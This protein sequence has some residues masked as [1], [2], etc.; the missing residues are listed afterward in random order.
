MKKFLMPRFKDRM[1]ERSYQYALV[2]H[3]ALYR[4]QGSAGATHR[5]AYSRGYRGDPSH[6]SRNSHGHA[7][8]AAGK[9]N[10]KL[11]VKVDDGKETKTK[12]R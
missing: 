11:G 5:E 2:S 4:K 6:Y 10:A 3:D 8:Y 1:M 7:Y 9:T 12:G